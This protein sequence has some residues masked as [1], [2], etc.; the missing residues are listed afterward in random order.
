V[1]ADTHASARILGTVDCVGAFGLTETAG[2]IEQINLFIG[3]DSGLLHIAGAVATPSIGLFGAVDP[4]K[5]LGCET[6]SIAIASGVPCLGCHHRNPRLHWMENCAKDI[7]C[8]K[9]IVPEMV[10]QAAT[11]LLTSTEPASCCR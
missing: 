4:E 1:G 10:F 9:N 8:M 11:E 2:I 7:L 6:P 5:R 3:I